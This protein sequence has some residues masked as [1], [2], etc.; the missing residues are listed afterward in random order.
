MDRFQYNLP[1]MFLSWLSTK[2]VQAIMIRQKN[3]AAGGG[4]YFPYILVSI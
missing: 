2:L 4:A 3:M 1:G